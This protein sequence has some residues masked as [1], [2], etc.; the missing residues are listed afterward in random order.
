[1]K[2]IA[3]ISGSECDMSNK[4]AVNLGLMLIEKEV[5]EFGNGELMVKLK[6]GQP[7]ENRDIYI[8][9]VISSFDMYKD[10]FKLLLLCR[11]CRTGN[12]GNVTVIIS[13]FPYSQLDKSQTLIKTKLLLNILNIAGAT[14][15]LKMNTQTDKIEELSNVPKKHIL[16]S[17]DVRVSSKIFES[18][19]ELVRSD[20][21]MLLSSIANHESNIAI[22]NNSEHNLPQ[23]IYHILV[24]ILPN[25]HIIEIDHDKINTIIESIKDY[26]VYIIASW[27]NKHNAL[28]DNIH[29]LLLSCRTCKLMKA[30]TIT[31]IVPCFP[32]AR[33][34]K[35]DH[36][37]KITAIGAKMLTDLLNIAGATRILSL[38]LH[39][40]QIE[41]FSD[42]P[43]N[44]LYAKN[45]F[46]EYLINNYLYQNKDR[47]V[48]IS[49]DAGGGKRAEAYASILGLAYYILFKKRDYSKPGSEP[50]VSLST[51]TDCVDE[52]KTAIII[53][54]IVDTMGTM[55]G[56]I[57]ELIKYGFEEFIVVATH[58][59]LSGKAIER[60]NKT[61]EISRVIVTDSI[62]QT[63]NMKLCDKLVVL[64]TSKLITRAINSITNGQ[65]I[66]NI[67]L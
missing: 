37:G 38:D 30:R 47:Y 26:D 18:C 63:E 60:I 61:E 53:D 24:S 9:C 5:T 7:I 65:S 21:D 15:I 57:K 1:M 12:A 32:Y 50:H 56:T 14:R 41:G 29:N 23:Q 51:V 49:P 45:M 16:S 64:K 59:I 8:I 10:I 40:G 2:Q 11:A 52:G 54:D 33:S 4:I 25:K 27:S 20:S 48:I 62:D 35:D 13:Q 19:T 46:I 67:Y 44:N 58:G 34:D 6:A 39:S 28:H 17:S 31:A 43:F 36:D 55:V 42:R 66:N 22:I 3:I